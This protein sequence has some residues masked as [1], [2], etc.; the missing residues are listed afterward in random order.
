MLHL[1]WRA[2][3]GENVPYTTIK[4]N[5]DSNSGVSVFDFAFWGWPQQCA[6]PA[7][8]AANLGQIHLP[9]TAI[10][11]IQPS[12]LTAESIIVQRHQHSSSCTQRFIQFFKF[13]FTFACHKD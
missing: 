13:C 5:G 6:L 10:T 12:E 1:P 9:R 3:P 7:V 8:L 2:V 4:K 11:V